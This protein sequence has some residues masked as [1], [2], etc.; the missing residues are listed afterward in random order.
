MLVSIRN[1]VLT[2]DVG[3]V[4]GLQTAA[5]LGSALIAWLIGS[6]IRHWLTQRVKRHGALSPLLPV[7]A[8]TPWIVFGLLLLFSRM[9]FERAGENFVLI[10]LAV[11]LVFAWVVIRLV[12]GLV[13]DPRVAFAVALIAWFLAAI[14]IAGLM[15]PLLDLLAQ[16][17]LQ[18]GALKLSV[19][20]I[21]KALLV[22][23][24]SL[25]VANLISRL[26]EQQLSRLDEITPAMQVLATKL[27]RAGLIV[28]AVVLSLGTVGIDL[29]AF[30]VFSGA[31]GVGLGFGLQKVV[32]NLISGVILLMD[33]SIKPGDVIQVGDTFGWITRL[34]ARYVSVNTRD[35]KE[36]LI[37]NED[38]ITQQVVNWTYSNSR[39]RLH[40][41]FGI[42][43]ESDVHSAMALAVEAAKTCD[44]V[45]ETPPP[46]CWMTGFGD[47][48]VNFELR[49]WIDDARLGTANVR[50][51][52][53]VALWDRYH[54]AGIEFPFPQRVVHMVP[55]RSDASPS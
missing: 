21:I 50:S 27:T 7:I 55:E 49:F 23:V 15:T 45:L 48:S 6:R 11:S 28:L 3:R 24:A 1:F 35:G 37:P 32:S 25:W 52:V 42:A 29:T 16:M 46:V 9:G 40:V 33:S 14:N 41:V 26:V 54:E 18:V 31:I 36:F 8:A 20:L 17:S 38:L 12:S 53:M 4:V 30:A 43:Y 19:L 2:P 10:R 13:R 39:V 22:L 44:R 5:V 47:S 51:A 34:N